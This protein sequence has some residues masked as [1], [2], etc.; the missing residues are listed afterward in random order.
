MLLQE[1]K[2]RTLKQHMMFD[3]LCGTFKIK[4]VPREFILLKLFKFSLKHKAEN[5][6][7][8]YHLQHHLLESLCTEIH[9]YFFPFPKIANSE[10]S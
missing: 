4:D 10:K 7:I 5:G 3:A 6:I 8:D 2:R 1:M 9:D